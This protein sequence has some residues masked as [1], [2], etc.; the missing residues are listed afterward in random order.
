MLATLG[1]RQVDVTHDA[2]LVAV[3]GVGADPP[4]TAATWTARPDAVLV[5]GSDPAATASAVA[6]W[7][8]TAEL[9]VVV[10]TPDAEVLRSALAAGAVGGHDPSGLRDPG[11]LPALVDHRACV[12]VG[13]PAEPP[14]DSAR[15]AEELVALAAGAARAGLPAGCV[16]VDVTRGDGVAPEDASRLD[17]IS[18]VAGGGWPVMVTVAAPAG[19]A[20]VRAAAHAVVLT[21]GARV[22]PTDDPRTT[23]RAAV[24]VAELLR[25]RNGARR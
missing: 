23:R 5:V 11:Y 13:A 25:A 10:R 19:D 9:P 6:A 16:V 17:E 4:A 3:V 18:V 21:R 12:I 15:R 20:A 24:V 8:S 2:V 1:S 14:V 22:L 7:S